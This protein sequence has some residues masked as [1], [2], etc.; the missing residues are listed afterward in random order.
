MEFGGGFYL[1]QAAEESREVREEMEQSC[2]QS[3][4]PIVQMGAGTIDR[5]GP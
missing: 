4:R 2:Q 5:N 3:D 1:A